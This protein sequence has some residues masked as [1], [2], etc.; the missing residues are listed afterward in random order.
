MT[1][2]YEYADRI[3]AKFAVFVAPDEWAR[4]EVRIKDLKLPEDDPNKE[5]N[6]PLDSLVQFCNT[7]FVK[8]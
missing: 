5:R 2:C 6:I 8:K 4:N 7:H 1:W 3:G